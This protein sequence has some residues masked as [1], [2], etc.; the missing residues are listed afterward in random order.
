MKVGTILLNTSVS[1]NSIL[2][3]TVFLRKNNKFAE[4]F[5]LDKNRIRIIQYLWKDVGEN[6]HIQPIGYID[7]I[8]IL[9][10]NINKENNK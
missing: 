9:Q 2:R 4:C 7:I 6:K 8:D 5:C 10:S 3:K 1:E